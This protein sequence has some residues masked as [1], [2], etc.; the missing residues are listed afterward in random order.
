MARKL[1]S[2]AT[3]V[4]IPLCIGVV[5][6]AV[7]AVWYLTGQDPGIESEMRWCF[8]IALFMAGLT[9]LVRAAT[10]RELRG[11]WLSFG[12]GLW[13]WTAGDNY[14]MR[15]MV[16]N[17][18]F[19]Y[20]SWADAGY[21]LCLPF[22]FVGVGLLIKQRV[23]RFTID[24]W[25]DGLIA[26]LAAGAL[27]TAFLGPALVGLTDGDPSVVFTNL[28]YPMGDLI[29]LGFILG[30]LVL[31]GFRRASP[32]LVVGTGLLIW[33]AADMYYLYITATSEYLGGL[34]DT[35]WP[36][37]AL[38]IAAG[39]HPA[40]K[41]R[42]RERG[43]HNS[44]L[45]PPAVS[46]VVVAAI[47][48]W[49]HFDRLPTLAVVLAGATVLAAVA[50]LALSFKE[51]GNLLR[52]L[53]GEVITDALTGLGNRRRLLRDLDAMMEE[54][55]GTDETF[56]FAL[57]DLDGFKSYNDNF[58]HPAGDALL[59]RLGVSLSGSAAEGNGGTA[60]RLG[61]DEFCVLLRADPAEALV[62]VERSRMALSETGE[63][64]SVGAS[65]GWLML[66]GDARDATEALRIVDQR[67]YE[68]KSMRSSRSLQQ[69][70]ELLL[71]ILHE[72]E[73]TLTEHSDGVSEMAVELGRKRG[74]GDEDLDVIARAAQLHDIGKIAIPD[75]MLR[76][77]SP[78]DDI[79][80]KL[81][82]RHTLIGE[83][84][85]GAAAAMRPAAVLV[86]SSHER[87]D[88]D[89]YPDGI[90]GEE[91]PLGSRIIF[92]SDSFDA[93]T[94]ERPYSKAKSEAEA[95]AELRR[96]AGGQF[97]PGLVE[98]FCDAIEERSSRADA[99]TPV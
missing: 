51:N 22:F 4:M 30:A 93:M 50:R 55:E 32:I 16:P 43:V 5:L 90:A 95:L 45:L 35:L 96:C 80:W 92:I 44:A 68:E 6:A 62:G 26:A 69:T 84:I 85:L 8:D 86:R 7:N 88:G 99:A 53:H 41:L 52:S 33:C 91:I 64:F 38:I 46:S 29:V 56:M 49:D 66:P 10:S 79:E 27:A 74:L 36:L 59:E 83:R 24:R 63:G 21:L 75:D 65:V 42:P 67:M 87:W 78:L 81:M 11:A 13:F 14:F 19:P 77:A 1:T 17:E 47:L 9:C 23:G 15:H 73:P 89:G 20:P 39:A 3:P 58:G 98:D 82:K 48:V 37:G 60:Y 31:S 40:L 61:G 97:D 71:R 18:Y 25:L 2:G 54:H 34:A 28:A 57:F 76:K 12:V 72:R 94:E 70:H